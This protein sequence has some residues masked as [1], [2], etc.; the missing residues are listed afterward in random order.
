[1]R[2]LKTR[3]SQRVVVV[4]GPVGFRR[5]GPRAGG[6]Q[7][8]DDAVHVRQDC[9]GMEKDA[10]EDTLGATEDGTT[11]PYLKLAMTMIKAR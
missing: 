6:A 5:W 2:T 4:D 11:R 9:G 8:A 7:R 10:F 1:M 3:Q